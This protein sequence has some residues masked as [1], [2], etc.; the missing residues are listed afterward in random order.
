MTTLGA[1][2]SPPSLVIE[3]LSYTN[4]HPPHQ[5]EAAGPSPWGG[6]PYTL[7]ILRPAFLAR[8]GAS[9]AAVITCSGSVFR[10]FPSATPMLTVTETVCLGAPFDLDSFGFLAG[11]LGSR[12][13]RDEA[14]TAP[15]RVSRG[16]VAS[17]CDLPG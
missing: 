12:S 4:H 14:S 3:A 15:L 1:I 8:Y 13:G 17:W 7:T 5:R 9:S 2:R 11:R 6:P 10:S 16:G